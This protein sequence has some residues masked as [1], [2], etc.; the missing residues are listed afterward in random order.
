MSTNPILNRITIYPVKSLDGLSLQ[1][2]MVTEGGCL[3]HDR[4]YA[5]KNE[6]GKFVNGK[7]N[8]LVHSLRTQYDLENSIISFRHHSEAAWNDFHLEKDIDHI[9]KYLS[10]FFGIDVTFQQNSTGRFLDIPDISGVSILSEASLKSVSS[11]FNDMDMDETRK[12]FRATLE[13]VGVTS[14]WEDQLFSSKGAKIEYKIGDVTIYGMSPRAR[15][16]VPTRHPETGEVYH[17]FAKHFATKRAETLPTWSKLEEY[18]HH[19]YLTVDCYVPAS[20]YGK[21]IK[22]GDELTITSNGEV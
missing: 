9:Q 19:Y 22:V 21:Y 11:W 18:G 12:R 4:E 10:N 20:E 3:I 2:A 6:F 16:V 14:F 1:Q 13:I 17:A 8:P 5:I 7:S 15:C